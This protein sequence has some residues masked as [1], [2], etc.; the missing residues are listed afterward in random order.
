MIHSNYFIGADIGGTH[1][2]TALVDL[3]QKKIVS[4]SFARTAIDASAEAGEIITAWSSCILSAK[5]NADTGA[6]CLA[7]PGPF[8]YE[9]GISLMQGQHKYEKLYGLN[10]KELLAHKLQVPATDIFMDND[11]ACFLHGEVFAGAAARHAD[12]TVIGITL[13]TGLG[14][15]IYKQGAAK[16]ANLWCM[17]FQEGIAEDYLSSGWFI[18]RFREL[19]GIVVPGVKELAQLVT[20]NEK[21]KLVFLEFGSHL[22][23]FL[24]QF[25]QMEQPAAVCIGG[26]I[27]KA[28]ALFGNAVRDAIGRQYPHITIEPSLLGEEGVL[29]GAVGSWF[30][31]QQQKSLKSRYP[32]F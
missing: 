26:N 20:T 10:I 22:A 3:Q 27:S 16:N 11:A 14:S 5:K 28:F 25:I 15:A 1:C 24:L 21:A 7:M 30:F 6:V 32:E 13:G 9:R 4:S 29:L 17:P 18:Q 12:E 31:K 19:T 2:S 8:D 23:Q